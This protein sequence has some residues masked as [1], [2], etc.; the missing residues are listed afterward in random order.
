MSLIKDPGVIQ[1]QIALAFADFTMCMTVGYLTIRQSQKSTNESVLSHIRVF[2]AGLFLAMSF[3]ALL[4]E[5]AHDLENT[6]TYQELGYALMILGYM[7]ILFIEKILFDTHADQHKLAEAGNSEP[8]LVMGQAER[9]ASSSLTSAYVLIIALVVHA[10]FE[11]VALGLQTKLSSFL[12]LG[13]GV[14]LHKVAEAISIAIA[15]VKARLGTKQSMI[16]MAIFSSSGPIGIFLGLLISDNASPALNGIMMSIAAGT[17]VYVGC[18]EIVA[19]EFEHS[20]QRVSKFLAL[21]AGVAFIIVLGF[22]LH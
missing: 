15:F 7:L 2:S 1:A 17:F 21:N 5:A 20:P 13:I 18:N 12:T 10:T 4:P 19:E 9:D 14:L 6:T 8:L 16:Y 11:G 3:L 22:A